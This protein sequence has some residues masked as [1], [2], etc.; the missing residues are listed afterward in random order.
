MTMHRSLLFSC[1]VSVVLLRTIVCSTRK[2]CDANVGPD[3]PRAL[4]NGQFVTVDES[5]FSK[6]YKS[7]PPS[8]EIDTKSNGDD[9]M[10]HYF[11]LNKEKPVLYVPNFLNHSVA[12]ELKEFCISGGRFV[13]S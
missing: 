11:V 13:R 6:H 8:E 7:F 5:R 2:E 12:E 4:V 10:L 3:R 1:V 9:I